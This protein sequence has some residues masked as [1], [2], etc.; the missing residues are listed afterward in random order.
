M[1]SIPIGCIIVVASTPV[2]DVHVKLPSLPQPLD[3]NS[4]RRTNPAQRAKH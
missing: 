3:D 1:S 4:R 2:N